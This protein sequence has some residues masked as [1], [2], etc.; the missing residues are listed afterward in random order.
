MTCS[1]L[2]IIQRLAFGKCRLLGHFILSQPHNEP[3]PT[4]TSHQWEHNHIHIRIMPMQEILK[5]HVL[6][7]CRSEYGKLIR[8]QFKNDVGCPHTKDYTPKFE[9]YSPTITT[10]TTDNNIQE[11]A[12]TPTGSDAYNPGPTDEDIIRYFKKRVRI[13][14]MTEKTALRLMDVPEKHIDTI[15]NTRET[16]TLKDGTTKEKPAIS[17]THRYQLAGNS[18]VVSCLFHLFR[19]LYIPGQ[20]ENETQNNQAKQMTLAL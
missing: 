7:K 19:T 8:K 10:M 16:Y 18:I 15:C 17:K 2:E 1:D 5:P 20:P 14:K 13:R 11:L 9:T 4:I 3:C 6:M 12:P